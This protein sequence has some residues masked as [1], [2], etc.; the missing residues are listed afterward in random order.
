M[1]HRQAFRAKKLL[2]VYGQAIGL[3]LSVAEKARRK[4]NKLSCL[5]FDVD[6]DFS[7]PHLGKN[8]DL[9]DT[10]NFKVSARCLNIKQILS[11]GWGLNAGSETTELPRN[12]PIGTA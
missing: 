1:A 7:V 3:Q 6:V 8:P 5:A 11:S 9:N 12:D 4:P 10:L 2:Q